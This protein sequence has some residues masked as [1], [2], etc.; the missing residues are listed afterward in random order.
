MVLDLG[1]PRELVAGSSGAAAGAGGT[2]ASGGAGAAGG[3]AGTQA[4]SGGD[5]G[6]GL[7]GAG[8]TGGAGAIG[9][10][11]AVGGSAG[12]S[13]DA[14]V[15]AGYCERDAAPPSADAGPG[16]VYFFDAEDPADP[17]DRSGDCGLDDPKLVPLLGQPAADCDD[18]GSLSREWIYIF[19]AAT[20]ACVDCFEPAPQLWAEF[21]F[22]LEQEFS[23]PGA[24][25][26][27]P[28]RGGASLDNAVHAALVVDEQRRLGLRCGGAS[29]F[30]TPPVSNSSVLML[31][32]QYDFANHTARLWRRSTSEGYAVGQL[33]QPAVTIQCPCSEPANGWFVQG[34]DDG[35][36]RLDDVRIAQDH[37]V[38]D[39]SY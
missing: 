8:A 32:Y 16:L 9:G 7:G 29:Q 14:G 33:A 19:H 11:G 35:A 26:F 5:A 34:N 22:S 27:Q 21:L 36:M 18:S 28:L 12:S 17:T 39:A 31:T 23:A 13:G 25:V 3:S 20:V 30:A 6:G 15:D 1:E 10:A 4:G 38:I 24:V 37:A 2:G